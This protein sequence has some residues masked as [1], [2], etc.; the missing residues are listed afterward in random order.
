MA[1]ASPAQFKM[2]CDC[3]RSEERLKKLAHLKNI[4]VGALKLVTLPRTPTDAVTPQLLEEVSADVR[5]NFCASA[6]NLFYEMA[7]QH[8]H[9][10]PERPLP[11]IR[12]LEE[13]DVQHHE[14]MAA[15]NERQPQT[16]AYLG[17]LP[18]HPI[19]GT[20]DIVP[21][22]TGADLQE[23]GRAQHNCVGALI[24]GIRA[25]HAHIYRVLAPERATLSIVEGASGEWV[26]SQLKATC[27][28]PVRAETLDAVNDWLCAAQPG[29]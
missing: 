10:Y 27:N 22:R 15:Y 7:V 2:L 4:N 23:E 26:I 24:N 11:V 1:S 12:S 25:G 18:K 3:V 16:A 5:H 17:P 19:A 13:L 28:N 9:F 14:I 21:L 6:A 29:L 8:Q 20:A